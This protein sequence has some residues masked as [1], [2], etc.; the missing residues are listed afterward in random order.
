MPQALKVRCNWFYQPIDGWGTF[1]GAAK[2]RENHENKIF[3][4]LCGVGL[5]LGSAIAQTP[6][7]QPEAKA[8]TLTRGFFSPQ[9]YRVKSDLDNAL[10]LSPEQKKGMQV[11]HDEVIPP[12]LAEQSKRQWEE[13][14][15]GIKP[16][17]EERKFA[18]IG[19][20][21]QLTAAIREL[22]A[23]YALLLTP[24]QKALVA[25]VDAA[26]EA[27]AKEV[28]APYDAKLQTARGGERDALARERDEK[29]K[30][31]AAPRL[32]TILDKK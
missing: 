31:V 32:E 11:A 14:R 8:A 15:R 17:A 26:V 27:V 22:R 12:I 21:L 16:T 6:A 2:S 24:E 13:R 30:A 10:S 28:G 23:R 19:L 20:G 18:M 5:C 4:I 9:S 3:W 29:I 25:K 7:A 1:G